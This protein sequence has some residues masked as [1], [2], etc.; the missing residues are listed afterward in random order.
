[1]SLYNIGSAAGRL[2]VDCVNKV[3]NFSQYPMTVY[4]KK[5]INLTSKLYY[6]P[7]GNFFKYFICNFPLIINH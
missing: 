1:M 4:I 7:T 3:L 6:I 5:C 2:K